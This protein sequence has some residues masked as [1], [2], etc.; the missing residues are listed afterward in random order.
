MA[1][2]PTTRW[3]VNGYRFLVRRMEHA[4][5]RRDVRMLHD[6]MRSQSRALA[7]GVVIASLGLAACAALALFRPQDKIGDASIVVAKDSGAMYVVMGDTLRPVLNLASARLIVGQASNPVIVKESEID[8]RPRGAVVGI[9][10]APSALSPGG[11]SGET[12]WTVCDSVAADG[13]RS[14]ATSIVV[15]ET[16]GPGNTA[17]AGDQALLVSASEAS[18]LMYGGKRAR[19]DMDD[20]AVT[21]ALGL[22]GARPRPVSRGLLNAVPEVPPLRA[23][24]IPGAGSRPGFVLQDKVVGSVFQV[25]IGSDTVHYVVLRDG[26]QKISSAVANLILLS[27]SQGDTE[28]S[29]VTPDATNRIPSVDEIPVSSFPDT[30]PRIV[31]ASENPVSCLTWTPLRGAGET[32]SSAPAA[33]LRLLAGRA[34]PIPEDARTVALAQADGGADNADSVYVSPGAGGFVQA[35]GIESTSTRRDSTFF[36]ADTGVRFGVPDED[37]SKALGVEGTPPL[38]PWQILGLLAPGPSLGKSAALVAHDGIAPDSAPA[39]V[40]S[41]TS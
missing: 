36:V 4:L 25:V 19:I 11:E 5:I 40:T 31:D 37:S 28:M 2:T 38:A 30:A 35:T 26:I 24:V 8:T 32:D 21:R 34:L 3:Q 10:G 1:V 17:L 15:G 7:V 20:P 9:P 6:P 39:A 22:E 12:P 16:E 41:G 27:N 33:E 23:P 13:H 29:S 14:V 18:Y